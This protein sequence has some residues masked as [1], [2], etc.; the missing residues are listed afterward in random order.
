MVGCEATLG[1]WRKFT[2]EEQRLLLYASFYGVKAPERVPYQKGFRLTDDDYQLIEPDVEWEYHSQYLE[3]NSYSITGEE[4]EPEP[5]ITP[6]PPT[7]PEL[8]DPLLFD[9]MVTGIWDH[10]IALMTDEQKAQLKEAAKSE[11]VTPSFR[12]VPPTPREASPSSEGAKS[13]GPSRRNPLYLGRVAV[14]AHRVKAFL[15]FKDVEN[16]VLPCG[17]REAAALFSSPPWIQRITACTTSDEVMDVFALYHQQCWSEEHKSTT[18]LLM[19]TERGATRYGKIRRRL[20]HIEVYMAHHMHYPTEFEE[21]DGFSSEDEPIVLSAEPFVPKYRHVIPGDFILI[22]HVLMLASSL[23]R[24]F[25]HRAEYWWTILPG[26]L[27]QA[28]MCLSMQRWVD[29]LKTCETEESFLTTYQ[30]FLD[31]TWEA[32]ANRVPSSG[33]FPFVEPTPTELSVAFHMKNRALILHDRIVWGPE[34]DED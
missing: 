14:A 2:S 30:S 1:E 33:T 11:Q 25:P 6:P 12:H 18:D 31:T 10:L 32:V 13:R 24:E 17:Q 3:H 19:Q 15:N 4:G 22:F 28:C 23:D 26:N 7:A 16:T 20:K 21:D 9:P 8:E 27:D 29:E 5:A 34:A